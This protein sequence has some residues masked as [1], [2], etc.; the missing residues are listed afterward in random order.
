MGGPSCNAFPLA[1]LAVERIEA[2]GRDWADFVKLLGVG[3]L[4]AFDRAVGER[5][6]RTK[7]SSPAPLALALELGLELRAA[8][9]LQR[10]HREG[11]AREDRV[12]EG[13]ERS[14][15]SASALPGLLQLVD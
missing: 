11:H 8:V 2:P 7:S 3:A 12:K 5:G 10:A 1:C 13:S 14:R 15:H 6:G 9:N 4:G